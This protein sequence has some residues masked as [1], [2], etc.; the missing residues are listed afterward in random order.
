[1]TARSV[2]IIFRY[3]CALSRVSRELKMTNG[4]WK[5]RAVKRSSL[6]STTLSIRV[7]IR[8]LRPSPARHCEP[9]SGEAIQ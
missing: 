7:R 9:R 1:M 3:P 5:M 4:E 6:Q 8:S 2:T